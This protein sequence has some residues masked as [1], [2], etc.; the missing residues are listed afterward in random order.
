MTWIKYPVVASVVYFS[1]VQTTRLLELLA[2]MV[3]TPWD[4][5]GPE[6]AEGCRHSNILGGRSWEHHFLSGGATRRSGQRRSR[7]CSVRTRFLSRFVAFFFRVAGNMTRILGPPGWSRRFI[8]PDWPAEGAHPGTLPSLH[9]AAWEISDRRPT[10]KMMHTACSAT[11][12]SA[13]SPRWPS[14]TCR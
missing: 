9:M 5:H 4:H 7:T 1:P 10:S 12:E 6:R 11:K 13:W 2:L 8:G 14:L 3:R